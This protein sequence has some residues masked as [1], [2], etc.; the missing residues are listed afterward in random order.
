MTT[1]ATASAAR[2]APSHGRSRDQTCQR[3]A[4]VE[5]DRPW[6]RHPIIRRPG[7]PNVLATYDWPAPTAG[8]PLDQLGRSQ[9]PT[10]SSEYRGGWQELFPNAGAACGS[11]TCRCRS[12]AR[13]PRRAG[14][15]TDLAPDSVTLTTA[16]RLPLTL[17]R[18]MRLAPD[19]P[20]LLI[21]ETVRLDADIAVPYLWGHHPAFAGDRGRTDRPAGGHPDHGRRRLDRCPCRPAGRAARASGH[22]CRRG[23]AARSTWTASGR[24]RQSGWRT[25]RGSVSMVAGSLIRG[26]A[27]GLGV[28]MAGTRPRSLTP[29]SGG[30]SEDQVDALVRPCAHRRHR[31]PHARCRRMASPRPLLAVRPTAWSRARYTRPG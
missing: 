8:E 17:E 30:R 27:T 9:R 3:T 31:A 22:E 29:G 25:C 15:S 23:L 1:D 19:R 2:P 26:V 24:V 16:T 18:R 7:G 21:E 14:T 20:T 11:W 5:L 6:R 13:S 12:T 10:G 4:E 28:A